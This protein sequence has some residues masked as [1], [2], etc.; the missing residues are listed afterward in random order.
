MQY[1]KKVERKRS[2]DCSLTERVIRRLEDHLK[3]KVLKVA[4]EPR[5]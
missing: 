1:M 5:G 3:K 2:R 4:F